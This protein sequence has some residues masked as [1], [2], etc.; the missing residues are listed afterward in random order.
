M[1][2]CFR[3][4]LVNEKVPNNWQ[5]NPTLKYDDKS[6]YGSRYR[7]S[8]QFVPISFFSLLIGTI[9]IGYRFDQKAYRYIGIGIGSQKISIFY[10]NLPIISYR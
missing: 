10:R 6:R 3:R 2:R 7:L 5:G 1:D 9:G 8:V 4:R